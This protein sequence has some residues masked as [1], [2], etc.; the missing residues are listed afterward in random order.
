[1]QELKQIQIRKAGKEFARVKAMEVKL[2]SLNSVR[3][4]CASFNARHEPLHFLILNAGV[5][6]ANSKRETTEDGLEQHFQ[7]S[8]AMQLICR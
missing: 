7:A 5:M 2:S 3:K 1:M 6:G 8:W 4:F